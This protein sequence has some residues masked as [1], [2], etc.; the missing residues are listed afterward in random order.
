M[1]TARLVFSNHN[2]CTDKGGPGGAGVKREYLPRIAD[3][4]LRR[5]LSSS[6]AVCIQGPKWC[7]KTWTAMQ[8]AKSVLMMQ[9]PDRT[10]GYMSMADA[11]PSLLLEGATPRLLDEWQMAPILWDAVR[12]AVDQR[13]A[14]GQFILT[15]STKPLDSDLMHSG[16]GRISRMRMRTMSLFESGESGGQISLARLFAGEEPEGQSATD[17]DELAFATA[18][19]GWPA[20]MGVSDAVALQQAKNYLDAVVETDVSEVDGRVKNPAR[21]R[22]LMKSLARNIAGPAT[23]ATILSDIAGD[24]E[25]L[26]P[27]TIRAYLAALERLFVVED[28]QAWSPALRSKTALRTTA[29]RHFVDPSIAV[30]AL[31]TSPA[32]LLQDF[33]TFGF[34]FES[35]CIRDLRIYSQPL[36]GDVFHYRDQTELEADAIIALHDGRWSAVEIKM[37]QGRIEEAASTLLRL[38]HRVDERKMNP[39]AFLMVLTGNGYA[40]RRKDGVLVV[41]ATCLKN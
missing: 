37:G 9:D 27:N 29:K 11:K 6:G 4:V 28:Q 23:V 10:S 32:G 35:L 7:G 38:K 34:L 24:D 21:V 40:F 39:P 33:R 36:S 20:A 31:Q 8:Q 30:A 22:A 16:T 14:M 15:G 5:A 19:G 25:S 26:S 3:E 13:G 17:I 41:P 2:D 18:R 1:L 12:F